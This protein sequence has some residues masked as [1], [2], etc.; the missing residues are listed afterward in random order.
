MQGN[1]LEL[2]KTYP[3]AFDGDKVDYKA[4]CLLLAQEVSDIQD[5]MNEKDYQILRITE[6][7]DKLEA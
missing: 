2:S 5:Q 4:L 6:R 1:L 7:L 3:S